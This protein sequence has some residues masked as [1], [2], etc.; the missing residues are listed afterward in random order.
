MP[1]SP[2]GSPSDLGCGQ[3]VMIVGPDGVGKT[4]LCTALAE[5][6][7]VNVPVRVL[8]KRP[9][10]ERPGILP[11]REPRGS[12]AQPHRH[13][14]YPPAISLG[15]AVYY[16]VDFS[17]GWLMKIV[18]FVVRGG[19]VIVE[20]GWWDMLVDPLRYRL[21]LSPAICR[22]LAHAMPRP[23]VVLLLQA[24]PEVISARKAQLSEAELHRQMDAWNEVLPTRQR[25]VC[26]DTSRPLDEV[27]QDALRAVEGRSALT[28][29]GE[30]DG[31]R[32]GD[33]GGVPLHAHAGD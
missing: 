7:S 13:A 6:I 27:V 23:T 11:H 30:T 20:R 31:P 12:S 15:K 2:E 4:A 32:S 1:G 3:V 16:T 28:G 25:R 33:T 17:L 18:P 26:L 14:A 8:A 21:E 19:C 24:P 10:A 29:P 9:G 5:R 22:V